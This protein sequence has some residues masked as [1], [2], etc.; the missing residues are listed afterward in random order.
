[1][2]DEFISLISLS[3][4]ILVEGYHIHFIQEGP[5]Y[6]INK[7][8]TTTRSMSIFI[9][10]VSSK[11]NQRHLSPLSQ[12]AMPQLRVPRKACLRIRFSVQYRYTYFIP[13]HYYNSSILQKNLSFDEYCIMRLTSARMHINTL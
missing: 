11:T 6:E 10:L 9:F 13:E 8:T 12:I 4:D 2:N 3:K 1:M 5:Q 7:T